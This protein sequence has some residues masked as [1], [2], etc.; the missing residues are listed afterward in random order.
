MTVACSQK[1]SAYCAISVPFMYLN[2]NN[3]PLKSINYNQSIN[4]SFCDS[5]MILIYGSNMATVKLGAV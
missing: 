2:P 4:Q 5:L 3:G 1:D